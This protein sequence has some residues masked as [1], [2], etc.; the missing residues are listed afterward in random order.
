MQPGDI[1][2]TP[3]GDWR[4]TTTLGRFMTWLEERKGLEFEDYDALWQWSVADLD[5]FWLSIW[6]FFDVISHDEPTDVIVDRG[7][8]DVQWFPGAT[9]NYAEHV[10]RWTGEADAVVA[11]SETRPKVELS[12]N[13]LRTAV[14]KARSGLIRLGVRRDD[15]VAAYLPNGPEAVIAY[16]AVASIGA[17]WSSCSPEF[18]IRG[19]VDRFRQIEP[20]VLLAI[21]GYRFGG[22]LVDRT[23]ELHEVRKAL[24]TL[25]ATV[26]VPYGPFDD[27]PDGAISWET[28]MEGPEVPL[29]FAAVPFGHPL[30]ILYSSGT[31]GPPKPIVHGH[32]GVLLEHLKVGGLQHDFAVGDRLFWFSTTGWMMWNVLV[33]GLLAGS[34][35]V[36]F[37]GSPVHPDPM[38]L[39]HL[40]EQERLH[41]FG[42]SAS[43]LM[44]CRRLDLMPGHE[45]DLSRLRRVGSTGS[46]LPL[47][48]YEWVYTSVKPDVVL[49]SS[50]GGTDVISGLVGTSPIVPIYAGEMSCRLLGCDVDSYDDVG[51]SLIGEPGELVV[52]R[53]IESPRGCW[54]LHSVRGGWRRWDDRG[55]IRMSFGIERFGWCTSGAKNAMSPRA[56]C[57]RLLISSA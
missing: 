42:V 46:P 29:E 38:Q 51:R 7:M 55:C 10:L 27:V 18:G 19:V 35:I 32:G 9:L 4:Q 13:Q 39:W 11:Y 6:S 12:R 36:L 33:S 1:L 23:A 56:G 2:W 28:L 34:T 31:T 57:R 20:K 47:D 45:L 43:F 15:R 25:A 26:V 5:G 52:K 41:H 14:A 21:T 49:A 54:R 16:L 44:A 48:G 30:A 17:V 3:A 24:P 53:P 22:K 40:A 50:S 8:P 37:D